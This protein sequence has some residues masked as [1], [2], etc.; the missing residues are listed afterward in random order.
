MVSPNIFGVRK[1][2]L[3]EEHLTDTF[4]VTKNEPDKTTLQRPLIT[5][6]NC[7]NHIK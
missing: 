5:Q 7:H 4:N 1:P 6:L 3:T 2:H